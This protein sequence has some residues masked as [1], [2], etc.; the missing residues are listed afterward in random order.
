MCHNKHH[1]YKHLTANH[2]PTLPPSP[3]TT[4]ALTTVLLLSFSSSSLAGQ[5]AAASGGQQP[6]RRRRR[7]HPH[8][9]RHPRA[10]LP[11]VHVDEPPLLR[12]LLHGHE[13]EAVVGAAGNNDVR[14]QAIIL[15]PY[16]LYIHLYS[17]TYTYAH[18]LYM[19]IHHIYTHHASNHPI[20]YTIYARIHNYTTT[21]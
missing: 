10:A 17:H 5:G 7:G 14:H 9:L 6:A 15:Y 1:I 11:D 16:T 2:Q 3:T 21:W 12:R 19:Y 20:L 8:H 18:P 4:R 13:P